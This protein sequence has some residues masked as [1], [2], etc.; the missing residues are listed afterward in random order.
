MW[1]RK[2]NRENIRF[3]PVDVI[4]PNPYRARQRISSESIRELAGSLER[5]GMLCPIT[6]RPSGEEFELVLGERR[7]MAARLLGWERVPCRVAEVSARLG[8]EMVLVEN[9]QREDLDLFEEASAME[10]LIRLF[11]YTQEELG[12]KL[13]QSQSTVAN[14][15]RLL[16]LEPRERLLI[17]ENG[18]SGRHA[19]ALLRISE[20]KTRMFAL[21]FIIEK[22]YSVAQ[23]EDFL[24]ALLSHPEEFFVCPESPPPKPRPVRR[25]VVRDVRLF[26]NSVDRA[27]SGIRQAGFTVEADK[28]EEENFVSYSIR[29]PK[30]KN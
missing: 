18:L 20:P 5:Y 12:E 17:V 4:L 27:I 7:L 16:R 25:L 10:R 14:K 11:H 24:E 23:T 6:V 13:G 19:R 1:K 9:L 3:L 8:A 2:K 29:I 15:L 30:Y 28:K 22:G 26:I 21:R